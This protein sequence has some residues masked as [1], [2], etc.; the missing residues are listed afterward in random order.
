[1]IRKLAS[2]ASIAFLAL[3]LAG[4]AQ[5]YDD[6]ALVA[7]FKK[8]DKDNDGTLDREEAKAMPRVLKN[9]DTI[10][11]DKDGL[12]SLDDIRAALKKSGP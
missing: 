11:T 1:M 2:T 12:V 3:A 6:A 9:F 8:A 5:A 7:R 10:D 4:P